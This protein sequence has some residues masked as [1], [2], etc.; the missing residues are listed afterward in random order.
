MAQWV[1]DDAPAHNFCTSA[2]WI[3]AFAGMSG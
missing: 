1:A 2:Q 3:P